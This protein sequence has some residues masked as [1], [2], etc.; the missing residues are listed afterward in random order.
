MHMCLNMNYNGRTT[1]DLQHQIK[2]IH[3]SLVCNSKM[4]KFNGIDLD[5]T[6]IKMLKY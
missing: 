4:Y 2:S 6:S 3:L 5:S 1:F